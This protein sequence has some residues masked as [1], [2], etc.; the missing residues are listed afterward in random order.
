VVRAADKY[1]F[2]YHTS[3]RKTLAPIALLVRLDFLWT[4]HLFLWG[5]VCFLDTSLLGVEACAGLVFNGRNI[6]SGIN[7]ASSFGMAAQW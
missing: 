6:E 1:P 5:L 4:L 3:L 2:R 7:L